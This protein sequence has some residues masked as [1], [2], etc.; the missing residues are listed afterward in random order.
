MDEA[1]NAAADTMIVHVNVHDTDGDKD[2]PDDRSI[3]DYWWTAIIILVV[4]ILICI[5]Y[6][7]SRKKN[8][9]IEE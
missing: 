1:G 3:L 9:Q 6:F 5:G 4:L 8:K 7:V 2:E